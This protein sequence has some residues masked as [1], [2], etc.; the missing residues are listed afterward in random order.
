MAEKTMP[1]GPIYDPVAGGM[2]DE[3]SAASIAARL[4]ERGAEADR[5]RTELGDVRARV[6]SAPAIPPGGLP[7]DFLTRT[8]TGYRWTPPLMD[9]GGALVD[10]SGAYFIDNGTTVTPA[11]PTSYTDNGGTITMNGA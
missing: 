10:I 5:I 9:T 11:H 3:K 2:L 8:A 6:E 1:G 4:S 7:G